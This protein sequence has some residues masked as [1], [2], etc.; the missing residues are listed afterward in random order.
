MCYLSIIAVIR[1]CPP[2]GLAAAI[3]LAKL[4]PIIAP[5]LAKRAC[6]RAIEKVLFM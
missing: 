6:V 3:G 2:N 5:F 4:A 1:L